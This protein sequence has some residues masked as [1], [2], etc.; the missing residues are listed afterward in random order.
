MT[1]AMTGGMTGPFPRAEHERRARAL[2]AGMGARGIDALLLSQP[3]DIFWLTGF[4]TRFWE[5]PARP[6]FTLLPAAGAPIAVIPS[7]GAA[8]MGAT[9]VEDIRTW[10]APVPE[11]EG[12]SLLADAVREIVPEAGCLALPLGPETATRMPGRDLSKLSDAVAPRR[13]VDGTTTLHRAREVK[14]EAEVA[15]IRAACAAAG[16][17]FDR[18]GEIAAAGAPLDAVF[19]AFQRLALEEGADWVGYLAGGAGPGGYADVIS[20]ATA[21]PLAPGDLLMLDLGAVIGGYWS[22]YDR[23]YAIG[24]PTAEAERAHAILYEATEA[25]IAA[26]RPGSTA[27]MVHTAIA[28]AITAAGGQPLDGRHG[29]GLGLTLT[30]WPSI[31]PGDTTELREGM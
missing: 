4:L 10:P 15:R 1:G 8:L 28:C 21:A 12:V 16:R 29:H 18:L 20:P 3:A 14:S 19:R 9:W 27:E 6:F 22:D 5:S 17:A 25:G 26:A 11:D 13:I 7:I 30:E 24:A 23:N 31:M 2:Q